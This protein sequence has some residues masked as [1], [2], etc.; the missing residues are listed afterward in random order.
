MRLESL[1]RAFLE[2]TMEIRTTHLSLILQKKAIDVS[3]ALRPVREE[4]T[5]S[6]AE[7]RT[8]V[9]RVSFEL[10]EKLWLYSRRCRGVMK[11]KGCA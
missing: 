9:Q 6:F 8:V 11:L 4:D 5:L 2:L 7:I 3:T 10:L 1:F